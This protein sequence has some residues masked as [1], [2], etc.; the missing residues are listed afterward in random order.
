MQDI[1]S[2][3]KQPSS[4]QASL[5]HDTPAPPIKHY[6]RTP[7]T[8]HYVFYIRYIT[9][10]CQYQTF[11]HQ[12]RDK[13]ASIFNMRNN[14]EFCTLDTIAPLSVWHTFKSD[15]KLSEGLE[16]LETNP[17]IA[18]IFSNKRHFGNFYLQT[19]D[20]SSILN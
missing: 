7:Q 20:T 8:H 6:I 16:A 2:T 18:N 19:T 1:Y 3:A 10:K 17:F 15:K 14:K 12:R 13:Q 5:P 11:P 4:K 9:L